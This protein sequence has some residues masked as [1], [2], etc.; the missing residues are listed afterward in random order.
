MKTV[1]PIE[2]N[3]VNSV[4]VVTNMQNDFCKPGGA[5]FDE[6]TPEEMPS[7]IEVVSD[8]TQRA[9]V[10]N[11][12]V[13]YVQSL[14]TLNEPEFE[15]Y[16]H[17]PYIKAGTWGADIIDELKP[18]EEDAVV[19]A[20]GLDAFHGTRLDYVLQGLVEDPTR[21]LALITGGDI[22]GFTFMTATDFYMRGYWTVAVIDALYGD[23]ES[24][25]FA[26]NGRFSADSQKSVFLSL[27]N[28]VEFSS[29]R[30]AGVAG[31]VPG[32]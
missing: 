19:E 1:H 17:K 24:R 10:A 9:R 11:V 8:L 20:W 3:P 28:L 16:G 18:H 26:L 32:T 22:G 29:D 13:I 31:L 5:I 2:A 23:D 4:L 6:R 7:V 30:V 27:S 12:P 14:R 21:R 25:A 15:V